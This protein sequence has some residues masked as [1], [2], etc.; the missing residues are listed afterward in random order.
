MTPPSPLPPRGW[1]LDPGGTHAWRWWDGT[2]WTKELHPYVAPAPNVT[3]ALVERERYSGTRLL[4]VGLALFGVAMAL[5][6]VIRLF[7]VS[8]MAA[9]WHWLGQAWSLARQGASTSSLPTPP[10]RSSVSANLSTFVVLPLEVVS[11][12]FVLKFQHRAACVAKALGL[13][14][15]INP[16]FGV[17]AWF[18]PL[19]NL[20]VPLIAW[21]DLLPE[22]HPRRATL[23]WVWAGLLAA[24]FLTLGV[25]AVASSSG[26][27][28][29]IL[30]AI[31]LAFFAGSLLLAHNVVEAVLEEHHQ[32]AQSIESIAHG[33]AQGI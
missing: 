31:Q 33:N 23:W 30:S 15:R 6:I 24:E 1:Y 16:T 3:K 20:I 21:L 25:F 4:R 22:R 27:A 19:V 9:T 8:W 18:L 26:L 7:D 5:S 11:L 28:V 14:T 17:I 2:A 12:V 29:G 13:T 32:A 10:T